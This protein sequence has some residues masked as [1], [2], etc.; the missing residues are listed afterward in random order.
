MAEKVSKN[1]NHEE[2]AEALGA[3]VVDAMADLA[4]RP[5]EPIAREVAEGLADAVTPDEP[6]VFSGDISAAMAQEIAEVY[7]RHGLTPPNVGDMEAELLT[8]GD[9]V[10]VPGRGGDP[11]RER[12]EIGPRDAVRERAAKAKAYALQILAE[13]NEKKQMTMQTIVDSP[14]YSFYN[15]EGRFFDV[16][17][18]EIWLPQ[19]EIR[20]KNLRDGDPM[21]CVYCARLVNDHTRTRQWEIAQNKVMKQ[22]VLYGEDYEREDLLIAAPRRGY[23]R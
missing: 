23:M 10:F 14:P 9:P 13:P 6:G 18:V 20:A 7:R 8:G 2:M 5:P 1:A 3:T 17:G 12:A 11:G 4:L 22:G 15:P 19:G 16:N 21:G